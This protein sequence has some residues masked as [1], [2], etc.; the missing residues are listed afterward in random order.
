MRS[1]FWLLGNG[2]ER[3]V[4]LDKSVFRI[5]ITNFLK[6]IL[7]MLSRIVVSS[8]THIGRSAQAHVSDR[9]NENGVSTEKRFYRSPFCQ[10]R[11]IP[12]LFS[13]N[14]C[15]KLNS[16]SYTYGESFMHTASE[17]QG[18]SYLPSTRRL[19]LISCKS[20]TSVKIYFRSS[21]TKSNKR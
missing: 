3:G 17:A 12:I 5:P 16:H 20:L 2:R 8:P 7:I 18:V 6:S 4:C 1:A 10:L 14:R 21:R 19:A 13:A 9:V 15:A 11:E